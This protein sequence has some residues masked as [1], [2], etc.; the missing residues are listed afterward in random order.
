MYTLTQKT[1]RKTRTTKPKTAEAAAITP[2][3]PKPKA[4]PKDTKINKLKDATDIFKMQKKNE[5][6]AIRQELKEYATLTRGAAALNK[7]IAKL[8]AK[9]N[10]NKAN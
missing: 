10:K 7:S 2:P 3:T 1:Q 9:Q 8:E 5:Q 6:A 4:P